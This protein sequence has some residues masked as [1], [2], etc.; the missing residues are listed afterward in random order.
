[1]KIEL[2]SS[3]WCASCKTLKQILNDI[4]VDYTIIDVDE[5]PEYAQQNRVKGLPTLKIT[6]EGITLFETGCKNRQHY[7]DLL[8]SL[9]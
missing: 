8:S 6:T 9:Y 1:M 5:Q 7:L 2:F 4:N 3:S